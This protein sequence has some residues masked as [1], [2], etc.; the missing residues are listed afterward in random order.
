MPEGQESPNVEILR[1][2]YVAF[3]Q[4]RFAL[5]HLDANVVWDE[6]RRQIDPAVHR[7]REEAR[8]VY[9]SRREVFEDFRVEA[10]TSSTSVIR[11]SCSHG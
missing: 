1:K 11:F 5:D 3:S 8:R 2:A 6:S 7:G 9:D 4:G 10:R